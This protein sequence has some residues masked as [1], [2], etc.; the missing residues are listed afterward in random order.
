MA[1]KM[2][3]LNVK[4]LYIDVPIRLYIRPTSLTVLIMYHPPKLP[5]ISTM[6]S[7]IPVLYLSKQTSYW[8]YPIF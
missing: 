1:A 7:L 8:F 6:F 3:A 4:Q 2:V 5:P